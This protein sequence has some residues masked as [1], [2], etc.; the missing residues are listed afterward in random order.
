M[1]TAAAQILQ[2]QNPNAAELQ[3]LNTVLAVPNSPLKNVT[4]GQLVTVNAGSENSA[5]GS[6]V[7]LFDFLTAAAFVANGSSS[8]SVPTATLNLAGV[9]F[10]AGL[11]LIQGPQT[12]YGGLGTTAQTSQAG[13]TGT[14]P[15]RPRPR[16][17]PPRPT[18]SPRCSRSSPT[19]STSSSG[20][21]VRAAPGLH[22]VTVQASVNVNLASALGT[23]TQIG[24]GSPKQ[25]GVS[26]NSGLVSAAITFTAVVKSGNLTLANVPLSVTNSGGPANGAA[27]FTLPP[28][29]LDVFKPSTARQRLPGAQQHE[30]PGPGRPRCPPDPGRQHR[31]SATSPMR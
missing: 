22:H 1:L 7:N 23:I 14:L 24:C 18:S 2:A 19:S 15:P 30:H 25:L 21:L 8:I 6:N 10:T 4:L 26:V 27:N 17:A 11:N 28:D 20:V 5:L 3:V 29:Q 16:S 31:S 12:A 13:L 9:T